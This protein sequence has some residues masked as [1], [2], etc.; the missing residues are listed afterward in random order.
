MPWRSTY[1][2]VVDVKDMNIVFRTVS[3]YVLDFML[4]VSEYLCL[5]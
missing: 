2:G 5:F 4:H 1:T 3:V